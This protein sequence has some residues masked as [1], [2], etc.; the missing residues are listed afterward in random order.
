MKAVYSRVIAL[1]LLA[2]FSSIPPS[3]TGVLINGSGAAM[4][5]ATASNK[6]SSILGN[7]L[8]AFIEENDSITVKD[9]AKNGETKP[10][11]TGQVFSKEALDNGTALVKCVFTGG[12]KLSELQGKAGGIAKVT[13]NDGTKLTGKITECTKNSIRIISPEGQIY[14]LPRSEL[15]LIRCETFCTLAGSSNKDHPGEIGLKLLIT[16]DGRV[17]KAADVQTPN[18]KTPASSSNN[19]EHV[20]DMLACPV[21]NSV[22]K[23]PCPTPV[24]FTVLCPELPVSKGKSKEPGSGFNDQKSVFGMSLCPSPTLAFAPPESMAFGLDVVSDQAC[25]KVPVNVVWSN[26]E[27]SEAWIAFIKEVLEKIKKKRLNKNP[28]GSV[29]LPPDRDPLPSV[30]KPVP[31]NATPVPN[32]DLFYYSESGAVNHVV[33]VPDPVLSDPTSPDWDPSKDWPDPYNGSAHDYYKAFIVQQEN[34]KGLD[35]KSSAP[36]A[37]DIKEAQ[38]QECK[39]KLSS[40]SDPLNCELTV[41]NPGGHALEVTLPAYT[42]FLSPDAASNQNMM[43]GT[44]PKFLVPAHGQTSL[45]IDTY[46]VS[47]KSVKTPPKEGLG[48]SIGNY[49]DES[50]FKLLRRIVEAACELEKESA[51][52]TVPVDPKMRSRRIAQAAI[53]LQLGK[54]SGKEN[55]LVTVGTLKADLLKGVKSE[56][57]KEQDAKVEQFAAKIF[58]AAE[59]TIKRAS[60]K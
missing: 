45:P 46:C 26:S 53:W 49:P 28:D 38:S 54:L 31:G 14:D 51:F 6:V 22:D 4:A 47:T 32:P 50:T 7:D 44:D 16:G 25:P 3:V 52:A 5:A 39:I 43:K 48:Y 8:S 59:S 58:E 1:A 56:L 19:F 15:A 21:P 9:K 35:E 34:L 60:S 37:V 23:I 42:C 18:I 2:L 41:E 30:K 40:D 29:K 33:V 57:S 36:A 12:E 13:L 17:F 10:I 24:I 55:D 11:L 27:L 20:L